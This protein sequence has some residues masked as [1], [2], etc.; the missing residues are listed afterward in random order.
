MEDNFSNF[1]VVDSLKKV[2]EIKGV[3]TVIIH[4]FTE[5]DFDVG[6]FIS[7]L[8][9]QGVNQFIYI[10]S[11]PVV[12]LKMV[13]N[14]VDGYYFEDEFYLEEEEELVCLLEDLGIEDS[15][16]TGLVAT[17]SIKIVRDFIEAFARGEE[18]IKVPMY[19][20]QVNQ[21]IN[22]LNSI[23]QRQ[24]VQISTMGNSALEVFEKAST[25]IKGMVKQNKII[26]EQLDEL[27]NSQSNTSSAKPLFSNSITF[28]QPYKYTGTGKVLLLRELTPCRYLTTLMLGYLHHLHYEKNKRVK[29]VFVHQKGAGVSMIYTNF[30][31][32]TQ[33]S[34]T[35]ESLYDQEIVA[36]NN[37]K[38][39]VLK[40]LLTK[41]NDVTIVVDRLYGKDDIVSGRVVKVNALSGKN[42]CKRFKVTPNDCI[43]SVTPQKVQFS[44]IPV[45][46]NF[47]EEIDAR[48]ATY[49]QICKDIYKKLDS[50]LGL[51]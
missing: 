41:Q 47:P 1:V 14:G 48:Y 33:E 20:E 4:T 16:D 12:T 24:E 13:L 3:D 18:R 32:I 49:A 38:K 46:K 2:R 39:E 15:T 22:E 44:C 5:S 6:V 45:I 26:Q 9:N 36:T 29:L 43:F 19:L 11:N 28:F 35:V 51:I 34:M 37:P 27:S 40:K 42:D 30:A 50:K 23:T 7:D 31:N 10:N 25:I 8:H 21:A 17:S